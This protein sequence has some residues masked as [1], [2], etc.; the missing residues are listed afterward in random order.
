LWSQSW[1]GKHCVIRPKAIQQTYLGNELCWVSRI[2]CLRLERQWRR[3][4]EREDW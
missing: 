3:G 4:I 1:E 2:K